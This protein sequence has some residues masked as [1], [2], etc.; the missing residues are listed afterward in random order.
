MKQ[1]PAYYLATVSWVGALPYAQ[2][3]YGRL[4]VPGYGPDVTIKYPLSRKQAAALN[5][6]DREHCRNRSLISMWEPGEM[7]D[8]FF[9][10]DDLHARATLWVQENASGALLF[11]GERSCLDPM[12]CV[13]LVRGVLDLVGAVQADAEAAAA[14]KIVDA[15]DK[16]A[17]GAASGGMAGDYKAL[18]DAAKTFA[19]TDRFSMDKLGRNVVR[20]TYP[21]HV[22]AN[23]RNATTKLLTSA[24]YDARDS[25][26][27]VRV[28][29]VTC[30]ALVASQTRK[31]PRDVS[32]GAMEELAVQAEKDLLAF[33]FKH[34]L[35]FEKKE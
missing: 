11:V 24:E 17:G 9:A 21:I 6:E 14:Q 15:V 3:Y 5:K 30:E 10:L 22:I 26:T 20:N 27:V 29:M 16:V 23:V 34:G 25:T 1:Y 18:A 7:C 2:H 19:E 12:Q 4:Q 32:V 33:A 28:D 8:R 35:V 13:E 31:L